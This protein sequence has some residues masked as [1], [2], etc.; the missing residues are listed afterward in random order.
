MIK[1]KFT[2]KVAYHLKSPHFF[3]G[4][5]SSDPKADVKLSTTPTNYKG[6]KISCLSH[7]VLEI[8]RGTVRQTDD[9]CDD[10]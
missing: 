10:R 8:G 7:L 6:D 2:S 9:R 3:T 5:A 4:G 1:N